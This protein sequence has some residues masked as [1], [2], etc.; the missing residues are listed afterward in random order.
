MSRRTASMDTGCALRRE[1][2][3]RHAWYVSDALKVHRF[4]MYILLVFVDMAGAFTSTLQHLSLSCACTMCG[5]RVSTA[6]ADVGRMLR[7]MLICPMYFAPPFV[8]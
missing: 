7:H 4:T 8:Q 3:R 2:I 6:T 1:E 5:A